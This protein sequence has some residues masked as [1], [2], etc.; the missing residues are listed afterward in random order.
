MTHSSL[1]NGVMLTSDSNPRSVRVDRFIVHHAAT[2][3]LAAILSLFQ[4]GGRTVSANYALGSDGTLILTVD[5]DRRAWT[6]SSAAWD[7]RAVTIEVANSYAGDPWPVS[8]ASFD[9]LARLIADVSLRHGFPINDETVLTHQEL[10]RRYGASYPTACPGD[11]Q[12]RKGELLAL[13]NQYRS[14]G[15]AG[16]ITKTPEQIEEEELMAAKDEIIS[17]LT[18]SKNQ[19]IDAAGRRESRGWRLYRNTD[20]PNDASDAYVAVNFDLA[21][22]DK[23]NVIFLN[24]YEANSLRANYQ[25]LGDTPANAHALD[26]VAIDTLIRLV[27]GEDQVYTNE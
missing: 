21:A 5:E 4:P 6:S 22:D 24:E 3:S 17:A 27:K 8:N 16:G 10:Y 7:G 18:A 23:R 15:T 12:R 19:I 26:Q 9:K 2:T 14:S 20:R 1:A 11:M 13:A 25:M